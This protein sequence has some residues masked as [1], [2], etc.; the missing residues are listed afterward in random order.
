MATQ[1]A[2]RPGSRTRDGSATS[3]PMKS[4]TVDGTPEACYKAWRNLESFPRF[5]SFVE[6]VRPHG[7]NRFHFIA[8]ERDGDPVE[9][10][11]DLVEDRPGQSLVWRSIPGSDIETVGV[12]TFE[13]AP[14]GRGT[15][16]RLGVEHASRTTAFKTLTSRLKAKIRAKNE[17]HR[18]KQWFETGEVATAGVRLCGPGSGS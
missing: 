14:G 11:V 10:D 5:L 1:I 7:D 8:R 15:I 18:F 4:I 12:V 9:W 16:I 3:P 2:R 6:A 17:L 13:K